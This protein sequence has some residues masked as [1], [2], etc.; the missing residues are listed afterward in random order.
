MNNTTLIEQWVGKKLTRDCVR[1]KRLPRTPEI[2]YSYGTHYPMAKHHVIDGAECILL[3]PTYYSRTTQRHM[4]MVNRA[5]WK[6]GVKVHYIKASEWVRC[7]SPEGVSVAKKNTDDYVK[8]IRKSNT[9]AAKERA[10]EKRKFRALGY[11][12]NVLSGLKIPGEI[13]KKICKYETT[14]IAV[15]QLCSILVTEHWS[16]DTHTLCNFS[17]FSRI[18]Q[19]TGNYLRPILDAII[20]HSPESLT[21]GAKLKAAIKIHLA[22]IL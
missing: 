11:R 13:Y 2:L 19:I 16:R 21:S 18:H 9:D 7:T 15:G 5:A 6:L 4:S 1:H 8:E 10:K 17:D 12:Q 22:L 3:N 14:T 20:E